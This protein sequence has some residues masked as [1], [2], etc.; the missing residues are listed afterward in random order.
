MYLG[1]AEHDQDSGYVCVDC[2][3][4]VDGILKLR[5][6]PKLFSYYF[7]F[8]FKLLDI[9]GKKSCV[10]GENFYLKYLVTH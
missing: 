3:L 8:G 6:I 9:K 10:E 7:W 4:L 2:F 1:C 5:L